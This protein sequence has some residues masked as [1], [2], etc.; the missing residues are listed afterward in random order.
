MAKMRKA[1]PKTIEKMLE[2]KDIY[3]KVKEEQKGKYA[4]L[5]R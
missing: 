1:D 5:V 3:E 4:K 2:I